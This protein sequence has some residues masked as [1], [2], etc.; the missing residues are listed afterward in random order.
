MKRNQVTGLP[1][2]SLEE[3]IQVG[4]IREILIDSQNKRVMGFV[5]KE[6][7]LF[8]TN[9]RYL[10]IED[11][12]T[13]GDYALTISREE[14]I[15]QGEEIGF[16]Q[17]VDNYYITGKKVISYMGTLQG[18]VTDFSFDVVKGK[19]LCLYIS[20]RDFDL[21]N[22]NLSVDHIHTLGRDVIISYVDILEGSTSRGQTHFQDTF[23]A[24]ERQG[25]SEFSKTLEEK[26]IDFAMGRQ[27]Y[28]TVKDGQGGIIINKGEKIKPEVIDMAREKNRL[29]QLLFAAGVNEVLEGLDFTR[30][31][32]DE[33]SRRLLE[34]W[35]EMKKELKKEG[36][37]MGK[38]TKEEQREDL[39]ERKDKENSQI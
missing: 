36:H 2:I 3:G 4:K 18:I 12:K 1:V 23:E 28:K 37:L 22:Y 20:N 30:L 11:I 31:K 32:I 8:Q 34:N 39:D 14:N 27:V 15:K 38:V 19:L 26:A 21:R 16:S 5:I 35:K 7:N 13:I 10:L 25:V 6:G 9:N 17:H 29:V 24:Q 33:G